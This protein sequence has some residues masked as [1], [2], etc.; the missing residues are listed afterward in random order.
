MQAELDRLPP[1]YKA[2]LTLR[3]IQGF[4]ASF[5][6]YEYG[7]IS[8]ALTLEF[9]GDWSELIQF[10]LSVVSSGQLEAGARRAVIHRCTGRAVPKYLA[11][12][13]PSSVV[14]KHMEGE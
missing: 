11:V 9:R 14:S 8:A 12:C 2:V 1:K 6:V 10:A 5:K 7:V 4:S 3:D 13:R